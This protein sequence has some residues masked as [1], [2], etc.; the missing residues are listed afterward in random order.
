MSINSEEL[1]YLVWRYLQESGF[2]TTAFLLQDESRCD[3]LD[4]QYA[5]YIPAGSLVNL[6]QRGILYCEADELVDDKGHIADNTDTINKFTLVRALMK[7][8]EL[9]TEL[10]QRDMTPHYA[11][12]ETNEPDVPV[13][14]EKT[15]DDFIQ[16]IDSTFTFPAATAAQWNPVSSAPVLAYASST[17]QICVVPHADTL[18]TL[19]H[20][21]AQSISCC[22]WAPNGGLLVTAQESGELRLWSTDG[23][24]RNVFFLHHLPV[25]TVKWSEDLKHIASFDVGGKL[26]VWD[27]ANAS[28]IYQSTLSEQK[29]APG[30]EICWLDPSKLAFPA[31]N[32]TINILTLVPTPA[33]ITTLVAHTVTISALTYDP[34]GK[35]LISSSDDGQICL[36]S[37]HSTSPVQIIKAHSQPVVYAEPFSDDLILSASLDGTVKVWNSRGI[38]VGLGLN[39]IG[40][41]CAEMSQ[42]SRWLATGSIDG[43][44]KI[45]DL[46]S[47]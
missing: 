20:P 2:A 6:T 23:K 43:D 5:P 15:T 38:Q 17:A 36:W 7:D 10:T 9:P 16:V 31:E 46:S 25:V 29:E 1:N 26:I 28:A 14:E 27:I 44:V 8:Q 3:R 4:E 41:S 11:K 24:L 19:A 30:I 22:A 13:Q 40:I 12:T 33:V 32:Y 35:R 42:D 39:D 47:I 18:L 37:G 21:L 34:R 45:W